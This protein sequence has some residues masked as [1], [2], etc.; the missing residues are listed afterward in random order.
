MTKKITF[1]GLLV[2]FT[3]TLLAQTPMF[4]NT[5]VQ[6]GQNSFPFSNLATS[7]KVT[8]YIPANSLGAVTAGNNITKVW[9][10]MGSTATQTYPIFNIKLKTGT[11]T[12]LT[13]TGTGPCETGLTVVY[14]AVN[15]VISSS[16]GGWFGFVL[17]T[18]W[19][20]NPNVGLIVEVEHNATSGSGPT[21]CQAVS[22]PG[23]G[24]GRQW[25][26][27][28]AVNNTGVGTNQV[29]FGI[30]VLPATPCTVAP[31]S[32]TIIPS[33]FTTCPFLTNPTMSLASTYSFGGITYQWQSSTISPVGP[34]TSIP[35]ATMSS[36]P[37]GTINTTTWFNV[38]ATCTNPGGGATTITPTQF[39]VAGG[40]TST[41]P[42]FEDFE[43]IQTTD[44]L[45]NCSWYA[46][47]LGSSV[48]TYMQS[49]SNNRVARSGSKFGTFTIPSSNNAVYSN[50]ITMSAGITYSAALWYATEYFGYN[51]WTNL[52]LLVGPNQSQ[53]S[54]TLVASTSPAISGPYKLLSGT[55]VVP[56]AGN[57]YVCIKATAASGSAVY[58]SWD[59]LSVTIPC[60]DAGAVNTPTLLSSAS[61]NTI[62][63]GD[64]INLNVSGA[65]SYLWDNGSS[66]P[67]T[68]VSPAV[69]TT[70][71]VLGTNTLTGCTAMSSQI[72]VV[73][74]SPYVIAIP[75]NPIACPGA[76]NYLSA[77][78]ANAYAW[79]TGGS[80]VTTTVAPNVTTTYSVIGTNNVGCSQTGTV[81]ITVKPQP[82]VSAIG[83]GA[84]DICANEI[85]TFNANGAAT[86]QWY[87]SASALV[88][89]G[90]SIT[91]PL[92]T[93]TTFT[94]I[95]TGTNGCAG[96]TTVSQNVSACT[97]INQVQLV[98]KMLAVF[99]NPSTG[100]FTLQLSTGSI[101]TVIVTD[102]AGREIS[103]VNGTAGQ[104]Q[105]DLSTLS[106]GVYYANVMDE[107]STHV[108]RLVKE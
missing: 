70:I 100:L 74:P 4:F 105:V 40:V 90:S 1:L 56:S 63:A 32:N 13:G 98:D 107:N 96:K 35:G 14:S 55:F 29:N 23:P 81:T 62:C 3:C 60:Y 103:R 61:A 106:A 24:N 101:K 91:L 102:L 28:L 65:D 64:Q 79:S 86:Y 48:N 18:P 99:P 93:S 68:V 20:Y 31:I 51:N 42:Y 47:N 26:D 88:Y 69:N 37:S 82:T 33:S 57:Y 16:T 92:T 58:L 7:R 15:Q 104:I 83:L 25:A 77:I 72:I 12:G 49:S 39:F 44:R 38:I 89:Q 22:I 87:S 45:P 75:A 34:F 95:G 43:G 80:G 41:I 30:D 8:W 50:G 54:M 66:A 21:V 59:D 71:N 36:A 53:T 97:G 76:I 85:T 11:G 73:N 84:S 52:Q 6:A 46:P 17:Q 5:N 78:G 10:Q 9:F 2:L 27:Y 19:L 67:T 108:V 94:V